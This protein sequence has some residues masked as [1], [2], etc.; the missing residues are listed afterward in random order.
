M[1]SFLKCCLVAS[2][3]LFPL[4]THTTPVMADNCEISYD[5]FAQPGITVTTA[6]VKT[7]R[8]DL[9]ADPLPF[10]PTPLPPMETE[11][12]PDVAN[13]WFPAPANDIQMTKLKT[14]AGSVV[15]SR[16]V[17][18]SYVSTGVGRTYRAASIRPV[19]RLFGGLFRGRLCSLG[20]C[21]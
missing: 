14:G 19:R 11:L 1:I 16:T 7:S 17:T 3:V 8:F 9:L 15:S 4:M 5:I 13:R 2:L 6:S 21:Y 10:I 12:T 20:S 18:E